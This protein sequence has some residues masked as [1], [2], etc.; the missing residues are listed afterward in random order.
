[1]IHGICAEVPRAIWHAATVQQ[2]L[3]RTSLSMTLHML[4]SMSQHGHYAGYPP[5][6]SLAYVQRNM[7][8]MIRYDMT[9]LLF[10]YLKIQLV[11]SRSCKRQ[12][13]Q[14]LPE[15]S[16]GSVLPHLP[17]SATRGRGLS[18]WQL[19]PTSTCQSCL[20]EQCLF[21]LTE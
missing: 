15:R 1:M 6:T 18:I 20:L 16:P 12:S 3:P 2:R 10:R 13:C 21:R 17:R 9:S 11:S 8:D 19:Q 4:M 7:H 14:Q 5:S